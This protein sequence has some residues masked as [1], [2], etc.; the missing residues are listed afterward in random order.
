MTSKRLHLVLIV[1]LALLFAALLGGVYGVN[2]LLASESQ[3]LVTAKAKSQALDQ[4]QVSL[5]K[6]KQDVKKYQSL[7]QIA[8]AVVPQDKN[9]AE[10]VREIVNIAAENGVILAAINFPA[11]TLGNLPN[12]TAA[13]AS[14]TASSGGAGASTSPSSGTSAASSKAAALSQLTALKTIPGVYQLPITI[15]NDANHPVRY[16]NFINFLGALEHNRRTSQVQTITIT[17]ATNDRGS[18]TFSLTLNEYIKP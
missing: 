7:N 10:A 1:S 17:P 2:K 16:G 3:K 6:A 15:N 11:S 9:Q 18:L 4:E 13:P 5:E 8:Q 12:G 14:G